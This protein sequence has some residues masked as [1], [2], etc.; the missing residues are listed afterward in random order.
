VRAAR[1]VER[2]ADLAMVIGAR[3]PE[4]LE[5]VAQVVQAPLALLVENSGPVADMPLE[6]I[7]DLGFTM[8]LYPGVIRYSMMGAAARALEALRDE[9]TSA[10]FRHLMA[11]PDEWNSLFG[12]DHQ[13][14][15]EQRFVRGTGVAATAT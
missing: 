7:A 5:R 6:Q 2:G 4:E 8:A 12:I 13:F 11:T 14:D 10:S 3:T 1:A 9:G 15:L